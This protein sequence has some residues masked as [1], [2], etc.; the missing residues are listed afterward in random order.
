M[1]ILSWVFLGLIAGA[2]GRW[3]MPGRGP[4]GILVTMVIGIAG[5]FIGGFIGAALGIGSVVGFDFR[6]LF[7]AVVGAVLLLLV[8]RALAARE[9]E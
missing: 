2:I 9:R 3:I 5:A 4:R 6:S 8:Y 7:L 1:G